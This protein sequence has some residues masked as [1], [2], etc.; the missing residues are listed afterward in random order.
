MTADMAVN[1]SLSL[2]DW[3]ATRTRTSDPCIRLRSP[4]H[5]DPA[6]CLGPRCRTS[7]RVGM[8]GPNH[9]RACSLEIWWWG[10]RRSFMTQSMGSEITACLAIRRTS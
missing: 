1:E 9:V 3:W 4:E 10:V 8:T 5:A 2:S 7:I 6:A